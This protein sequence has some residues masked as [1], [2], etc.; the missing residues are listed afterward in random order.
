VHGEARE[1]V[2]S[3][4][5]A[6]GNV[7][8]G[9]PDAGQGVALEVYAHVLGVAGPRARETPTGAAAR[10]S[11]VRRHVIVGAAVFVVA[12]VG[13]ALLR[14]GASLHP[15]LPKR[16]ATRAAMRDKRVS[17][18]LRTHAWTGV[19]VIPFDQHDWRVTYTDG[20]RA[21]LDAAVGPRGEVDA[22]EM[23]PPGSHPPGSKTVWSPA[24]LL[25]FAALFMLA[26]ARRPLAS[27][28]NA[29]VLVI[30]VGFTLSALLLDA[31]LV[32]PHVFTG[33]ATLA[34][35]AVRCAQAGFGRTRAR[36]VTTAQ[37]SIVT[38]A[39]AG[40]AVAVL[41]LV[42]TATSPSD[43]ALAH[44]LGA[45]QL[46]HG[47]VPYG[48]L[49]DLVVHGDT[50]PL[51][52]YVLFMPAAAISPVRDAFD[53]LDGALWTNAVAVLAA[54]ALA[55]RF[56]GR[57]HALA[58]LAFPP[59]LLAAAGG[60][61]DVPAALF[62][63]AAVVAYGRPL[64]TVAL[65]TLAGWVKVV[66][67]A[68][69]VAVLVRRRTRAGVLTAAAIVVAGLLALIAIGGTTAFADA[70]R[71][72]RF[73]FVRGSWYSI[74]Q[75]SGTRTL[76]LAFQAATVAYAAVIAMYVHANR[77]TVTRTQAFAFG[78]SLVALLQIGANYWTYAYLPWLFP[79]ILVAL[80]PPAPPRSQPRAPLAP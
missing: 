44:L 53:S 19:H 73:Q 46:N 1:Q 29:D 2:A 37:P 39:C 60:G 71:G 27:L 3:E 15:P 41:M 12:L 68:G 26:L 23:R 22:V 57:V 76:Q 31:R 80:F 7:M 54:A 69:L 43:V 45:T 8:A 28:Q 50:Y 61:N 42:V 75:Q 32:G 6:Q 70:L 17:G 36:V 9:A 35:I 62:V 59:V 55:W 63:V 47:G 25:L 11:R 72:M 13:L 24:V 5:R 16:D 51:L 40:T 74:W 34:W 78:G 10:L 33:A 14:S 66:P 18:Y 52:S 64:L 21:V 58:W 49:P 79:F 67:A 65:L 30:A 56:M 77:T 4:Q 48:H 38:L 20:P